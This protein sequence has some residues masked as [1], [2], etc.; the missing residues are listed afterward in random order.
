MLVFFFRFISAIFYGGPDCL[1]ACS[2]QPEA[3]ELIPLTFHVAS[4]R[5]VQETDSTSYHNMAEIGEVTD[6]VEELYL[7]WPPQW[8]PFNA[9]AIGVVTPYTDQVCTVACQRLVYSTF[10]WSVKVI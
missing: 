1:M 5:E 7:N 10:R 2:S 3:E 8:G 9:E 6:Q 4:G